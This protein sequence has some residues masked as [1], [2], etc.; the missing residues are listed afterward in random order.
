MGMDSNDELRSVPASLIF[1]KL[2]PTPPECPVC[3][4]ALDPT[5]KPLPCGHKVC[6]TGKCDA[7][8]WIRSKQTCPLCRAHLP[9]HKGHRRQKA[10]YIKPSRKRST[11]KP[12]AKEFNP[13]KST[14]KGF[15]IMRPTAEQFNPEKRHAP[16]QTAKGINLRPTA[17]KF[18]PGETWHS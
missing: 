12:T 9:K 1:K 16:K 17:K 7:P 4:E 5:V 15:N 14:T 18:N 11:L 3:F 2:D 10:Y 8:R 13:L 6:R